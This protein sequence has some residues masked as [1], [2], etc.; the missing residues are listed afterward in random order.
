MNQQQHD[1]RNARVMQSLILL[2]ALISL[3]GCGLT[4]ETHRVVDLAR[5][6][7]F[8]EPR[9]YDYVR[10]DKLAQREARL[11]AEQ[12]W[13]EVA[14]TLA[15]ASRDYENGFTEGF[16]DYLYR[17]GEGEPPLIPP[18]G[19]WNLRFLNQFGKASTKDWYAGFRHGAQTCKSTGLRDMWLVPTSLLLGEE[20]SLSAQQG[21]VAEPSLMMDSMSAPPTADYQRTQPD[22]A[23]PIPDSRPVIEPA[24][25]TLQEDE[26]DDAGREDDVGPVGTGSRSDDEP[27]TPDD[28]FGF[29]PLIP[30]VP[31]PDPEQTDEPVDDIFQ[32]PEGV[33]ESSDSFQPDVE[34][35][36]DFDFQSSQRSS[37]APLSIRSVRP[38]D[39]IPPAV[40]LTS[41]E[42]ED[43]LPPPPNNAP[44]ILSTD[45][46][47]VP[48]AMAPQPKEIDLP[49]GRPRMAP[50][51]NRSD[52]QQQRS[53]D[54]VPMRVSEARPIPSR[55]RVAEQPAPMRLELAPQ[56]K[57]NSTNPPKPEKPSF[58]DSLLL[59]LPPLGLTPQ[60]RSENR[61]ETATRPSKAARD[62]AGPV[63]VWLDDDAPV[64]SEAIPVRNDDAMLIESDDWQPFATEQSAAEPSFETPRYQGIMDENTMRRSTQWNPQRESE[65]P[66]RRENNAMVRSTATSRQ[67]DE[68]MVIQSAPQTSNAARIKLRSPVQSKVMP[69]IYV[70]QTGDDPS[71][72]QSTTNWRFPN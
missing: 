35:D 52:L 60:S 24:E 58:D 28:P 25:G 33:F 23:P 14:P 12:A 59:D 31:A 30:D 51:R 26:T 10:S 62:S 38:A 20:E 5:R 44:L 7:T 41:G 34:D 29:G 2:L 19:Y 49:R 47:P 13:A 63:V 40:V 37:R 1:R 57:S 56:P 16:A 22:K 6:T 17:G 50:I 67:G 70:Q 43:D 71:S 46:V 32:L 4:R 66:L 45:L 55:S 8:L 68:P 61:E 11:L 3:T 9:F 69:R 39:E 65:L 64:D 27:E 21:A 18:R 72:A 15:N 53:A 54:A 48:R 36:L 42:Y